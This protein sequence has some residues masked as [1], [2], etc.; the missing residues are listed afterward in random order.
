MAFAESRRGG[1]L[2]LFAVVGGVLGIVAAVIKA[3]FFWFF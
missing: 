1:I 2:S 3:V